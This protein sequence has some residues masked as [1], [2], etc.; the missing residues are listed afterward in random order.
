MRIGKAIAPSCQLDPWIGLLVWVALVAG[1]LF[2]TGPTVAAVSFPGSD[3]IPQ[4]PVDQASFESYL[5]AIGRPVVS[6]YHGYRA[7]YSTWQQ[8]RQLVY[9]TPAIVPNNRYDSRYRE[10]AYLG[11]SFDETLVSNSQFPDDSASGE[12]YTSPWVWQEL[13]LGLAAEMSWARLTARQQQLVKQAPLKYRQR[14]YG[15]MTF[16]G[17]GL[18]SLTSHVLTIPAWHLGFALYTQHYLPGTSSV[19]YATLTGEGSGDVALQCEINVLTKIDGNDTLVFPP[20]EES[21]E[22]E[23]E[24]IGWIA[25]TSG[26][27]QL[28]DIAYRGAGNSQGAVQGSGTGPWA[29][30]L[31][32]TIHRS[33]LDGALQKP[34]TLQGQAWAVSWMGD[35]RMVE[36]QRT[37]QISASPPQDLTVDF[38]VQGSLDYFAGRTESRDYLMTRDQRRYLGL[39][40]LT[41]DARF[42]LPPKKATLSFLGENHE[43]DADGVRKSFQLRVPL[44]VDQTTLDWQHRRI[45]PAHRVQLRAIAEPGEKPGSPSEDGEP[46][47]SEPDASSEEDLVLEAS[48]HGIEITGDIHDI[49]RVLSG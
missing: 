11:Y 45:H 38:S 23:Y 40:V 29:I 2:V 15:G 16:Q 13:P 21:V 19:R 28:S 8:D 49:S 22:I 14:S 6:R 36:V 47:D 17:L 41:F 48:I 35:I 10:Y 44:P 46:G 12:T 43:L 26:L 4:P 31:R 42:S 39:E 3:G 7:N 34:L 30:Q 25:G 9:G 5:S 27:A 24:V 37:L 18:S 33:E 20:G 1:L 32:Q